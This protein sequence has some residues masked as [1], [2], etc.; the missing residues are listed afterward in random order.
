MSVCHH[1]TSV[2]LEANSL[3]EAETRNSLME[4]ETRNSLMEAE[5]SSHG[6]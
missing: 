4:G 1:D 6:A 5:T 3:M 2:T